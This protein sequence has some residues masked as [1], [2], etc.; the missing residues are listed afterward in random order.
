MRRVV[1]TGGS[2]FI[3]ANLARRVLAMGEELHLLVRPGG[4][5]WRIRDIA[6][7]HLHWVDI[8][9]AKA[10]SNTLDTIRPE[11]IFHLAAYGAYPFQQDVREMCAT[12]VMGTINV[13]DAAVKVGFE[14]FVHAGS[15]SEYGYKDHAPA[16]TER[17]E[18]NSDYAVTKASATLYCQHVGRRAGAPVRTLRLYS[19]FGMWEEPT[20]L[21]PTLA[22]AGLRGEL[23]ALVKPD[24]ARDFVYVDD[25]VDAFI[26]AA[27][28]SGQ[29]P[30]AIYNLGTG[31][32]TTLAEV[33]AVARQELH[34]DAPARW[35]SMDGRSWDTDVWVAD[36]RVLRDRLGWRLRHDVE[37][38]FRRLAA[39]FRE[40]PE[41][42]DWYVRRQAGEC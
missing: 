19:V 15:S 24:T 34:V 20:R 27:E 12:N 38:G 16:E 2:G 36:A 31:T 17:L 18:P 40:N 4:D 39:W 41:L 29:E 25:T 28:T 7:A 32:Q 10:V 6:A 30:G 11:W 8:S 9:D 42:L 3:G 33:V 1:I 26:L 14:A 13:L 22:A 5:I 35:G 21:M 23:P 37:S